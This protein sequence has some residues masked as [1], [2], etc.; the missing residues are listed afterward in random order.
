M[1]VRCFRLLLLIDLLEVRKHMSR[2]E[3]EKGV[4]RSCI[5]HGTLYTS[6]SLI[7]LPSSL[8]H[9]MLYVRVSMYVC[10]MYVV[11]TRSCSMGVFDAAAFASR[12]RCP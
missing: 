5:H 4:L 7:P 11:C 3:T 10:S 12:A 6:E 2:K 1:L 8:L 9:S